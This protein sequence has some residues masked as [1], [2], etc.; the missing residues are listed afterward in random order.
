MPTTTLDYITA[1]DGGSDT[2]QLLEQ[3][4]SITDSIYINDID[5]RWRGN[6]T[7]R[8]NTVSET[9][10]NVN[11]DS[12]TG[13]KQTKTVTKTE[14]YWDYD[15]RVATFNFTATEDKSGR[16]TGTYP[17]IPGDLL[18]RHVYKS[19]GVSKPYYDNRVGETATSRTFVTEP[20]ET[21][22]LQLETHGRTKKT[23]EVEETVITFENQE[24]TT[25]FPPVPPGYVFEKH[26]VRGDTDNRFIYNKRVGDTVESRIPE[27]VGDT[28]TIEA[29]TYGRK[30]FTVIEYD[31]TEY[32]EITGDINASLTTTLNNDETTSIRNV[33][34]H[35]HG[36][37]DTLDVN[38][39]I[40]NS[41]FADYE[42]TIEWEY[43]YALPTHGSLALKDDGQWYLV[44]IDDPN[45]PALKHNHIRLYDEQTDTWGAIDIAS[46]DEPRTLES[47]RFYD[48]QTDQWFAPRYYETR[49]P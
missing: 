11:T 18:A 3:I 44:A 34:S 15:V 39:N 22:R 1:E 23:R 13:E 41:D 9:T 27:S 43:P 48:N 8:K 38:Y 4:D 10:T 49:Q 14:E 35:Q 6:R 24:A 5:I 12:S 40:G 7:Q 46:V 26:E 31:Q 16:A 45:S 20:G 21:T 30:T 2:I 42:L 32:A 37:T 29:V 36:I 47:Y 17:P 19:D 25:S 28:V 33:S